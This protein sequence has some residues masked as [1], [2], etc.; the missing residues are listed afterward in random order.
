MTSKRYIVDRLMF[1]ERSK[2]ELKILSTE[3]A[4]YLKFYADDILQSLE[5]KKIQYSNFLTSLNASG[6]CLSG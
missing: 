5:E 2:E 4:N 1:D 3:M 6:L